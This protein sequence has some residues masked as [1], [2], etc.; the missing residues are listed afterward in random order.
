MFLE[1]FFSSFWFE[2]WSHRATILAL[3][4][5]KNQWHL[6][7]RISQPSGSNLAWIRKDFETFF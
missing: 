3:K 1:R 5:N 6:L 2:K 4:I 7:D